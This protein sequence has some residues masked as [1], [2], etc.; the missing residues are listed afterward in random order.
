M[1]NARDPNKKILFKK[2]KN[3]RPEYLEKEL[4]KREISVL[5]IPF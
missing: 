2:L 1:K 3:I 4:N 5:K